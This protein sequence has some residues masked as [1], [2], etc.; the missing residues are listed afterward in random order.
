MGRLSVAMTSSVI[1][2]RSVS[3]LLCRVGP[4]LCALPLENVVENLRPLPIKPLADAPRFV[5]GL[6]MIRGAPVPV[7]DIASLFGERA[8]EPQRMVT[9]GAEG[10]LVALVVESVLGVRSLGPDS[11][12]AL[13]P[14]LRDACGEV[15]SAGGT[16]DAELVLFLRAARIVPDA[17]W[18]SLAAERSAS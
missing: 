17:V 10:R 6:C 4:R 3:W 8:T 14:L 12:N 7:V 16:L 5:L 11:F 15:V 1:D 9:L 18:E 2:I 13:P